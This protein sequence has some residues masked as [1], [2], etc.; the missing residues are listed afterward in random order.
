MDNTDITKGALSYKTLMEPEILITAMN[1][2]GAT[3]QNYSN[4]FMR[5]SPASFNIKAPSFDV[6]RLEKAIDTD[7][8]SDINKLDSNIKDLEDG[9]IKYKFSN[10][11]NFAYKK[12][13]KALIDKYTGKLA[14][15]IDAIK[16]SDDVVA[17]DT[18]SITGNGI[19][20]LNPEGIEIRFGRWNIENTFG[21]ENAD[22]PLPM[23]IQYWHD[24]QFVTNELDS[25]TTFDGNVE[26]NYAKDNNGLSPKLATN[27]VDVS[28]AGP[29]FTLGR[30]HLL[31]AKP[32]DGSRGQIRL[33]YKNVPNWL[34]FNWNSIDENSDGDVYDDNPSGIAT[35]G[36]YRGNDRIISWREIY[37]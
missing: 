4:D 35:F 33:T 30:G 21:P 36:V 14:L 2:N 32:S 7:V 37:K 13:T 10:T 17:T 31:L 23:S 27:V 16:D 18:D 1:K 28:G 25:L 9:T 11:D 5:L 19:L 12:N 6:S 29:S 3:T 26:A 24:G 8:I 34:K 22:L 20:T 15:Q